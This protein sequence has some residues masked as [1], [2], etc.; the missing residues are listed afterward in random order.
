MKLLPGS[1][2]CGFDADGAVLLH[3][4][5]TSQPVAAGIAAEEARFAAALGRR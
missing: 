1:L 4:L 5:D 2:P 3:C